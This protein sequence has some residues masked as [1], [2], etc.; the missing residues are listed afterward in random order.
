MELHQMASVHPPRH[1]NR[2]EYNVQRER[3]EGGNLIG[4]RQNWA[5]ITWRDLVLLLP[6]ERAPQRSNDYGP[7]LT[8]FEKHLDSALRHTVWFFGWSYVELGVGFDDPSASIPTQDIQWFNDSWSHKPQ[9]QC[10]LGTKWQAAIPVLTAN[11]RKLSLRAVSCVHP[12]C[13]RL[14][15]L[16]FAE[17]LHGAS[18][19]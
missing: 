8:E 4:F 15:M 12:F 2:Q 17:V 1:T 14:E 18:S 3:G 10:L 6:V 5:L 9:K 7:K 16:Q 11:Y 19:L 13:L